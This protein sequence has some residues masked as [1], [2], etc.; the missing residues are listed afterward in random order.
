MMQE[1][2]PGAADLV[3]PAAI[4]QAPRLNPADWQLRDLSITPSVDVA[5]GLPVLEATLLP[6]STAAAQAV[7]DLSGQCFFFGSHL[8]RISHGS[9]TI[10]AGGMTEVW[11]HAPAIWRQDPE[12]DLRKPLP[13]PFLP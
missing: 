3:L 2:E 4:A 13:L 11:I 9:V 12:Q 10:S 6:F 1:L 5:N 8:F 7:D